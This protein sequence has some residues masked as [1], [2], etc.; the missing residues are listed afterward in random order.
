MG[1]WIKLYRKFIDWEWYGDISCKVIFLHLLLTANWKAKKWQG[2]VIDVGE[3]VTSVAMLSECV[4]LSEQQTRTALKKLKDS[5]VITCE[6]T[7]K[8]TIIKVLNYCAY[9]SFD[10][11]EQ[12]TNNEQSTNEQQTN[13]KQITNK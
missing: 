8:Y 11:S 4:G 2:K 12:Q 5:E 1:P 10:F 6:A 3:L 9:Q 7:N 13:N